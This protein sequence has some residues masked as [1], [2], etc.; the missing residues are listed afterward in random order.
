M[1]TTLI[2]Y[3]I[4]HATTNSKFNILYNSMNIH[5]TQ[6][7]IKTLWNQ[8]KNSAKSRNIPFDLSPTDIDEIGIPITC[9]VLGIPL[10]FNRN[11]VQDDSLSF[12]RIDSSKGYSKDNIIIVSYK[13]NRL[14]SNAS[15]EEMNKIVTFYNNLSPHL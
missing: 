7:D 2:P 11:K 5:L 12:D 3:S 10:K 9:P 6:K 1:F 15:L 4:S 8:L 13:V 14:K